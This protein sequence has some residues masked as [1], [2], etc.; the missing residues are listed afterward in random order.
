MQAER[1]LVI[2]SWPGRTFA[3]NSFIASFCEALEAA[4]CEVVDVED[5]RS[6]QTRIDVLHI[7]W[8]EQIFW[9]GGGAARLTY[10]TVSVLRALARLRRSGVRLVWMVHNLRPH[11][12]SGAR[13]PLWAYLSRRLARM[14]D[15]FMTLSPA[16]VP[17]VRAA[18]PALAGK[19]F[20]DAWHPA[21][22][23]IPA[24]E[25]P[26]RDPAAIR[27]AFLG[28]VRPYKGV[29]ELVTAFAA[30]ADP[31]HR[32]VIAGDAA[33]PEFAQRIAAL[34][35]RDDRIDVELRRLSDAEMAT[36]AAAADII[37]LPFNNYLH[38]GSMLYALSCGRPVLTPSTAFAEG[39]AK[40][41]G[42]DWVRTY[43]GKLAPHHLDFTPPTGSAD[44][45]LLSW[46]ALGEAATALYRR[47]AS[48]AA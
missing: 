21:Y 28:Q 36:A 11:D 17:V 3:W 15:G 40:V 18:F 8:P 9:K 1:R 32:L 41:V 48:T 6:L 42:A 7:H 16:T 27:Y 35:A 38:S 22:T 26:V 14:V 33:P 29:E 25:A 46:S 31:R 19:P 12:E 45:G 43:Q 47:L 10:R 44:L 34:G 24:V 39:L 23:D 30:N 4:G 20:A 13:R 5:P 37:V 2:G